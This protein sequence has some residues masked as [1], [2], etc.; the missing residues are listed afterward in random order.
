MRAHTHTLGVCRG[1]P[2]LQWRNSTPLS[3]LPCEKADR[4]KCEE[5]LGECCA[6]W[7]C[8]RTDGIW[9]RCLSL[10][11]PYKQVQKFGDAGRELHE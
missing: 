6:G 8:G 1:S 3:L 11:V 5:H 9:G 2:A 10:S 7:E 4:D